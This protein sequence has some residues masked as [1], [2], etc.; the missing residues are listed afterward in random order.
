MPLYP[1]HFTL[2]LEREKV[3]SSTVYYYR[4][5]Q[6]WWRLFSHQTI[7][8]CSVD[9]NWVSYNLTHFWHQLPIVNTNPRG[10]GLSPTRLPAPQ[11]QTPIISP[12]CQL[13]F[14]PTEYK[15]EVPVT[16]L[17]FSNLLEWLTE[18]KKTVYLLDYWF[19]RNR[20]KPGAAEGEDV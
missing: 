9:T 4:T 17:S 6:V 1:S 7:L 10:L 12:H 2:P 15:L 20:C 19:I 8:Q 3:Y 13:C 16:P 11:L 14:W 18:P 5:H